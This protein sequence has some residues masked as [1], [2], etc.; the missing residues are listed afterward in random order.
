M[1]KFLFS[2]PMTQLVHENLSIMMTFAFSRKPLERYMERFAGEWEYLRKSLFEISE[3]RAEKAC[4]EL[5]LFL[6]L[7]DDEQ[8]ISGYHKQTGGPDFGRLVLK[9]GQIDKLQLRDVCNK[10]IHASGLTWDF[11]HEADPVLICHSQN[12]EKW[13]RAEVDL[14]ALAGFCG[15]IMS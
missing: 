10:I 7:V 12:Q 8:D 5:A 4:L 9:N 1:R 13:V 11:S 2:L 14:F 6:R 3:Q 15:D